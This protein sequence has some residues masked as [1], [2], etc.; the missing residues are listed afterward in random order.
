[1]PVLQLELNLWQQLAEAQQSPQAVDAAA[2]RRSGG[3][4]GIVGW[5]G[6]FSSEGVV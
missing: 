5:S 2:E 6:V 1:M 3:V 4:S